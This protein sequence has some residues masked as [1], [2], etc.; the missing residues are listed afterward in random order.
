MEQIPTSG[1]NRQ[2]QEAIHITEGPLL[3]FQNHRE[4]SC[5]TPK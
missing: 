3:I 1:L 2:Q 5:Q 4:Y